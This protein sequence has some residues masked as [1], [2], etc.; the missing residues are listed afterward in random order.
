MTAVA[1]A[2]LADHGIE[3]RI[4]L[5]RGRKQRIAHD[6][7]LYRQRHRIEIVFSKL[8]GWRR[9]ATLHD[10]CAHTFL[11]ATCLAAILFWIDDTNSLQIDL[12]WPSAG[13]LVCFKARNG[14]KFTMAAAVALPK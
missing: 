4:P 12:L 10:R 9:I 7:M 2:S 6:R 5:R 14:V 13:P 3:P 11:S 1:F 8:K